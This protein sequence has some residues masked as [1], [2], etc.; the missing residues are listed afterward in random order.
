MSAYVSSLG[1]PSE[2]EGDMKF[3]LFTILI[4]LNVKKKG[5]LP[6]FQFS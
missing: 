4:E 5:A 6:L 1:T 3:H 2:E